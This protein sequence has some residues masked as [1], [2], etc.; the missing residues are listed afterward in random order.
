MPDGPA[1]DSA[2]QVAL[3]GALLQVEGLAARLI[4]DG[5]VR[6]NASSVV[7]PA[8]AVRI[9][10]GLSFALGGRVR[11]VRILALGTRRG[12]AVEA[13]ALYADLDALPP[14]APLEPDGEADT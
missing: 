13:Q 6:V 8:T 10:D 7:K 11:A 1:G 9:G 3:A 14:A 2:R 4:T 12:P 5:V